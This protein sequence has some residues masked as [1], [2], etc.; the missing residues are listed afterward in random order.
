MIGFSRDS[1][2]KNILPQLFDLIFLCFMSQRDHVIPILIRV[3]SV[4][5]INSSSMLFSSWILNMMSLFFLNIYIILLTQKI[6]IHLHNINIYGMTYK[7][8]HIDFSE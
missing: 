1:A 7:I 8:F 4:I 2:I 5:A 3:F 6:N